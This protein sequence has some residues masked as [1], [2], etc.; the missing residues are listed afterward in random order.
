MRDLQEIFNRIQESKKEKNSIQTMFKDTL[1][2]LMEYKEVNDQINALKTRKR[3]IQTTIEQ[4]FANEMQR[5]DALKANM[6]GDSQMLSDIAL[7]NFM[8]G[9]TVQLVDEQNRPYEPKFN[10][11]FKKIE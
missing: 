11:V 4:Q 2:N 7:T 3:Q 6:K 5:L 9:E 8:K 1:A 10:I